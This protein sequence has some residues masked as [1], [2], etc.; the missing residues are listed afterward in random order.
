MILLRNFDLRYICFQN[1]FV[2]QPLTPLLHRKSLSP[3]VYFR[4]HETMLQMRRVL[5]LAP[6]LQTRRATLNESNSFAGQLIKH[7]LQLYNL[8]Q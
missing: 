3:C 7:D 2:L 5:L 6:L 4:L 8:F 1:H